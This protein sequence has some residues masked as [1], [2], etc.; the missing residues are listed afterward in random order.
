MKTIRIA[1][2]L[3]VVCM[4]VYPAAAVYNYDGYD[5]ATVAHD[6]RTM[7]L[8]SLLRN[9]KVRELRTSTMAIVAMLHLLVSIIDS[10]LPC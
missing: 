2:L 8:G 6:T 4:F 3:L 1:L 9:Q 7:H 10:V 5:L